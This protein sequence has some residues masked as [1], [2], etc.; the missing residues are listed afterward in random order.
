MPC[1]SRTRVRPLPAGRRPAAVAWPSRW[2]RCVTSACRPTISTTTRRSGR[3]RQ[4]AETQRVEMLRKAVAL[5]RDRV[6]V[7]RDPRRHRPDDDRRKH[8]DT[9][10]DPSAV[11]LSRHA[12]LIASAPRY[13]DSQTQQLTVGRLAVADVVDQERPWK[14][15]SCDSSRLADVQPPPRPGIHCRRERCRAE[16]RA[17]QRLER[18]STPR[19]PTATRSPS[20][21][22]PPRPRGLPRPDLP[23]HA[24]A[25]SGCA[26]HPLPQQLV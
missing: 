23:V 25:P 24:P 7:H 3:G 10:P 26:V 22:T 12:F 17:R 11:S 21:S 5:D 13:L 8:H 1:R 19:R 4:R 20:P 2:V 14:P 6:G 16:A 15:V 9:A 18:R